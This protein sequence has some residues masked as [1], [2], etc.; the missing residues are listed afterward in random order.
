MSNKYAWI[1]WIQLLPYIHY[2][3]KM[4]WKIKGMTQEDYKYLSN[5]LSIYVSC[6]KLNLKFKHQNYIIFINIKTRH[7][8][9]YNMFVTVGIVRQ[10]RRI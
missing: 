3:F 2:Q 8:G 1:V 4:I 9:W 5:Y 7:F 10:G 6:S